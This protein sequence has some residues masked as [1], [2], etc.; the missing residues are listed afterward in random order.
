MIK[1]DGK[2]PVRECIDTWVTGR[3][4]GC[5]QSLTGTIGLRLVLIDGMPGVEVLVCSDGAM[6]ILARVELE[7]LP[8]V[9]LNSGDTSATVTE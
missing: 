6:C 9:R 2:E 4:L 1:D 5:D 3:C 7:V 8:I